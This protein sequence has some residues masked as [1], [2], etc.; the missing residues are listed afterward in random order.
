MAMGVRRPGYQLLSLVPPTTY[1]TGPTLA[2][3]MCL[4]PDQLGIYLSVY[5]PLVLITLAAL[6]V[7]NLRRASAPPPPTSSLADEDE[8]GGANYDLPPP[9]AW[10]NKEFLPRPGGR[11]GKGK[12]TWTVA[13]GGRPRSLSLS[14]SPAAL[15]RAAVA[16]LWTGSGHAARREDVANRRAGALRGFLRD[17]RDAAWAPLALFVG[18]A[19]WVW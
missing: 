17:F 19:W 5:I 3:Q 10:R 12:W 7:S 15:R 9:S 11:A 13:I 8:D 16:F 1:Q 14:L 2:H 18:I 4:L 6:L